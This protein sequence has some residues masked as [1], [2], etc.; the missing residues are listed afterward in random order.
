MTA[1]IEQ[2]ATWGK[3][4]RAAAPRLGDLLI[5]RGLITQQQMN[6]AL[7]YQMEKRPNRLLGK[8]LLELKMISSEDLLRTMAGLSGVSFINLTTSMI[9]ADLVEILP[10]QFIEENCVLPL[11]MDGKQLS[12]AIEDFTNVFLIE[13]IERLSGHDV[14]V[15][16]ATKQNIK[17]V[18]ESLTED[19]QEDYGFDEILDEMNSEE[20]TVLEQEAEEPDDLEDAASDSPVINLVNHI[21]HG[22]IKERASDIHIEPDDGAF[23]VRYRV[24]GQLF[25]KIQPPYSMVSAVI[26]RIKIMA[27]MDIAERRVPQDGG[28]TVMLNKRP[29]DLRVSTMATKFGEKAVIRVIDNSGTRRQLDD[30]GFSTL[31][32]AQMREIISEKNGV[33]LVTGPTGSGKST[34]L[35]GCLAEI[36]TPKVNVSTIEDPIE[37]NMSHV[38]QFQV[39]TK[40]GFTFAGALRALLR[41]DPDVI[42]LGEVRDGE[43]AKIA[44]QAALTGHLVLSTLHTNDAPSA[45]TR[46]INM[47]VEPYLVAASLRG[48]LA[49]RLVR[50]VCT[51]CKEEVEISPMA[52]RALNMMFGDNQ[53]VQTFYGGKGCSRC[54]GTGYLGRVGIY[55]LLVPNE[56]TLEAISRG[57]S[58]QEIRRLAGM[59]GYITL[60]DDGMEKVKEGMTSIDAL[61]E[62]VAR[63]GDAGS[64]KIEQV[65]GDVWHHQT[66]ETDS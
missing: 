38:N 10:R 31:M 43:T 49:Q 53:P 55:E 61:L 66:R 65:T 37:Y 33:F 4:T 48:V 24:D 28:I 27:G 21:I 5:Q 29:I 19:R 56:S 16:A 12:V 17:A 20:L 51:N 11:W 14:R 8:V 15:V 2:D 18:M 36:V 6:Q 63:K 39:N 46:L 1:E 52:K 45:V 26:S 44:I 3:S 23:R 34:T 47:E 57:A 62:V 60:R 41:Q 35:Y 54:R 13:D 7:A 50:K 30:Q 32:L 58:L 9:H 42:M 59:E 25:E 22:A 64:K 40:A